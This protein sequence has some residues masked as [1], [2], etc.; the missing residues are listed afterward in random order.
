[1]MSL[2]TQFTKYLFIYLGS[3]Q[4]RFDMETFFSGRFP[5]ESKFMRCHYK[6]KKIHATVGTPLLEVPQES[7]DKLSPGKQVLPA[8]KAPLD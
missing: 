2:N 1:M 7:L 8:V 6:K 4:F 5:R 3:H